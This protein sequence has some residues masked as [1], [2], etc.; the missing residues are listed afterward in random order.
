MGTI[1]IIGLSFAI[2]LAL[3]ALRAA[4][5]IDCVQAFPPSQKRKSD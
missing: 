1:P 5:G 2:F 3:L 4:S